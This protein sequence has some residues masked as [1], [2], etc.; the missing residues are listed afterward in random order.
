MTKKSF[1]L[2]DSRP[3]A[4]GDVDDEV[5]FHL[6]MRARE[7]MEQ[8]MSA[9]DARR[10]AAAAFG[11]VRSIRGDLRTERTARNTERRRREWWDGLRMDARYALRT[12]RKN[13]AFS[14]AA[15]AT[16]ALGLGATLAVFT[17]VNGVLLRPLPYRNAARATLVWITQ[18][19]K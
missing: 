19:N 2:S 1:R 18:P 6:E 14:V 9:E 10:K 12:L 4:N 3:D 13:P 8:G 16:L 15:I 5:A 11:D 17:V 7:F